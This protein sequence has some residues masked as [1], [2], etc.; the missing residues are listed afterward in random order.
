M[1]YPPY[2]FWRHVVIFMLW[3]TFRHHDVLYLPFDVMTY[4]LTSWR[5]FGR[6][7]IFWRTFFMAWRY[8]EHHDVL[9]VL[10][11]VMA[12]FLTSLRNFW[13]LWHNLMSY[14]SVLFDVIFTTWCTFLCHDVPFD[15]MT[16]LMTYVL[17]LWRTFQ[18]FRRS[19]LFLKVKVTKKC[20]H[21]INARL[22]SRSQIILHFVVA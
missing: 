17:T 1:A 7:F 8:F 9:Y 2:F 16:N 4:F 13:R 20:E 10:F 19:Y 12:Y 18:T 22:M 11:D 3:R 15:V 21:R 14:L 5:N 6:F